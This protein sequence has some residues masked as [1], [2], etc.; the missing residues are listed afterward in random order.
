MRSAKYNKVVDW[1]TKDRKTLLAFYNFSAEQWDQL[2]P[3][4]PIEGVFATVRHRTVRTKGSLSS[5]TAMWM[6]FSSWPPPNPGV[7]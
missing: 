6:V 3:W 5:K 7:D 4:N 1:L 2:R